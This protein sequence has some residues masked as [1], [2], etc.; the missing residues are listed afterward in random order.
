MQFLHIS[1]KLL[2][3]QIIESTDCSK[4]DLVQRVTA[5]H[6]LKVVAGIWFIFVAFTVSWIN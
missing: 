6:L 3:E 2:H 4:P 5:Y 1:N